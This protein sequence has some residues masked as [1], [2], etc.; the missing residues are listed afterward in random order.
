MGLVYRVF[1]RGWGINLAMKA[2]RNSFFQTRLQVEDFEREAETWVNLEPHLHIVCC[3]Y[4]RRV[5]GVPHIFAEFVNGGTL[6]DWIKDGRLY[7]GDAKQRTLR[8]LDIAIQIALALNHAHKRGVIHQDVKPGN[9]LMTS[10]G[11]AKLTD[12]GL[13]SACS[14]LDPSGYSLPAKAGQSVWVKGGGLCTPEYAAPEQFGSGHVSPR[15]DGWSWALTVLEMM[16]GGRAWIDGRT[17]EAALEEYYGRSIATDPIAKVLGRYLKYDQMARPSNLESAVAD[18]AVV[19]KV[20]GRIFP[21][22]ELAPLSV[23]SDS[24]N[25]RALSLLEIGREKEAL[26]IL[27]EIYEKEQHCEAAYNKSVFHWKNNLIDEDQILACDDIYSQNAEWCFYAGLRYVEAG[28]FERGVYLL[29]SA[30]SHEDLGSIDKCTAENVIYQIVEH[31]RGK[32]SARRSLQG[33]PVSAV[34]FSQDA[35]MIVSCHTRYMREGVKIW[36]DSQDEHISGFKVHADT[37]QSVVISNDRRFIVTGSRDKTACIIDLSESRDAVALYGHNAP[38]TGV[39]ISGTQSYVATASHDKT[40]RIWRTGTGECVKAL[41][42]H[43]GPVLAV[44]I[45]SDESALVTSTA[46]HIYFWDVCSGKCARVI[47]IGAKHLVITPDGKYLLSASDRGMSLF[48]LASGH[49][50]QS[51]PLSAGRCRGIGISPDAAWA[52]SACDHLQLWDL[53]TATCIQQIGIAAS[54]VAY[55]GDEKW[56]FWSKSFSQIWSPLRADTIKDSLPSPFPSRPSRSLVPYSYC[57][58]KTGTM[59][60]LS[61]TFS[62]Q[63]LENERRRRRKERF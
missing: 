4:V 40:A 18:L 6:D 37:I 61:P 34:A 2:P 51:V 16:Q 54:G 8:V 59:F 58:P 9:I 35:S 21:R 42:G 26:A 5:D 38:V 53:S 25:N 45:M 60:D 1:H 20:S 29:Q 10:E 19:E 44:A 11:M 12:F 23:P 30:I 50:L 41:T 13:A 39:S 36:G 46:S 57:L 62:L 24:L 43:S 28:A 49:L 33:D 7:E 48:D 27:D 56:A 32:L 55:A 47:D 3:H 52:A 22:N 17:G 14:K 15:S 31:E 63:D